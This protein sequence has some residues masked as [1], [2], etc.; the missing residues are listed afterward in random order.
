MEKSEEPVPSL[1]TELFER[2]AK[3]SGIETFGLQSFRLI[4]PKE[5]MKGDMERF[6]GIRQG[7]GVYM[8]NGTR[9]VPLETPGRVVALVA[10]VQDGN[11][12]HMRRLHSR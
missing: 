12:I 8:L 1:V 9:P 10:T 11:L 3:E 4:F 7:R 6:S 5:A 2:G